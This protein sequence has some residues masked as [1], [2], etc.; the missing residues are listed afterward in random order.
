MEGITADILEGKNVVILGGTP[1]EATRLFQYTV[2]AVARLTP[3]E[4]VSYVNGRNY[5]QRYGIR[6]LQ[7]FRIGDFLR[8]PVVSL[9]IVL[10]EP[11]RLLAQPVRDA[12]QAHCAIHDVE[13]IIGEVGELK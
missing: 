9:V 4:R 13:L 8:R 10:L 7:V 12:L 3:W 6:E 1:D 5:A 11:E 2:E